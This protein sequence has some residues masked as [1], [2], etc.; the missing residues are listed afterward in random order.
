MSYC[1]IEE[2]W[3]DNFSKPTKPKRRRLVLDSDDYDRVTLPNKRRQRK[4]KYYKHS[5]IYDNE[6]YFSRNSNVNSNEESYYNKNEYSRGV[7]ALP[8]HNGPET[9]S[10][11]QD[12]HYKNPNKDFIGYAPKDLLNYES[13]NDTPQESLNKVHNDIYECPQNDEIYN[14][15]NESET[16]NES[17][18]HFDNLSQQITDYNNKPYQSNIDNN[19]DKVLKPT[20]NNNNLYDLLL[21]IFTIIFYLVLCDFI[22][23]LGKKTY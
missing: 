21:Y 11:L 10:M 12:I 4:P 19:I 23:K 13:I 7:K 16:E 22:Y 17:K 18:E 1:S 6:N 2:A 15:D 5:D 14:T 9:R 3:G 20:S 8:N